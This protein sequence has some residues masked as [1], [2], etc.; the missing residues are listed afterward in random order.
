MPEERNLEFVIGK[1]EQGNDI[2]YKATYFE[3]HLENALTRMGFFSNAL[4]LGDP[5]FLEK[6]GCAIGLVRKSLN[7]YRGIICKYTRLPESGIYVPAEMNDHTK[8]IE[9]VWFRKG[10]SSTL[11][12]KG[13]YSITFRYGRNEKKAEEVIS[14]SFKDLMRCLPS[15]MELKKEKIPGGWILE[16]GSKKDNY[17]LLYELIFQ[18]DILKNLVL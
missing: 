5:N 16:F 3:W 15:G 11:V 9:K 4:R 2:C 8:V 1:N 17:P 18:F 12:Q 6:D 10:D 13:D 7:L 14:K